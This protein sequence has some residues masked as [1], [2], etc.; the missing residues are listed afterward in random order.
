MGGTESGADRN[1]CS[2][3]TWTNR[4]QPSGAPGRGLEEMAWMGPSCRSWAL[5]SLGLRQVGCLRSAEAG[6]L[7]SVPLWS[8]PGG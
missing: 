8:R 3:L 7:Q 1:V 2:C 6:L 4:V 5:A